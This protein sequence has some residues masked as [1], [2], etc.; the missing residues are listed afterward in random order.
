MRAVLVVLVGMGLA[1]CQTTEQQR[2][3]TA[4]GV[5]EIES[6]HR[7]ICTVIAGHAEG[8]DDYKRCML[9]TALQRV[10]MDNERSERRAAEARLVAASAPLRNM[11]C[12]RDA[13]GNLNCHAY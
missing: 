7:A 4:R 3:E 13:G 2:A 8:S 12:S 9:Q 6:Q 11:T 5:A 10:V 1:G